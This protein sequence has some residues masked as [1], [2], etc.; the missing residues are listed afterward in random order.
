MMFRKKWNSM[1]NLKKK[2]PTRRLPENHTSHTSKN[3]RTNN[4]AI[5]QFNNLGL[6]AADRHLPPVQ[7]RSY[8]KW[9]ENEDE[10]ELELCKSV[11]IRERVKMLETIA[12][13][14]SARF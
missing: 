8:I 13:S 5:S 12:R 4:H 3:N 7:Q 1:P 6:P 14:V 10:F 9:D 11:S 2:E